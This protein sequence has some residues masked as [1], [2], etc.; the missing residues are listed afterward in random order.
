MRVLLI[1][2]NTTLSPYPV[3]P[4]GMSMVAAA[5]KE[6]G[7]EVKLYDCLHSEEGEDGCRRVIQDFKPGVIGVSIRNVD[8]VNAVDEEKYISAIGKIVSQIKHSTSVPVVLGGSGFSVMPEAVMRHVP[9]DYGIVGEGEQLMCNLVDK[10]EMGTPPRER[11]LVAN[12]EM[13]GREIPSSFYDPDLTKRYLKSGRMVAVQTKRGCD[14]RCVY[15][16]YP[17]IEGRRIRSRD[18][19]QVVD[20]LEA[21]IADHS[22]KYIFFVDSVFNDRQGEYRNVVERMY[23][24]KVHVKWTAFFTPATELDEEIL[25]KMKATGL[26]AVE[27]GADASSD[28]TLKAMAK[29]FSWGVVERFNQLMISHSIHTAHYFMFGGPGETPETVKQG[30]RNI[31]SLPSTANFMFMGIRILPGTVLYKRALAE[32][33]LSAD[34]DMVEPVYYFSPEIDPD[35]LADTLKKGFADQPNCVFPPNELDKDLQGLHQY[36]LQ[37]MGYHY[38]AKQWKPENLT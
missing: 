12:L 14:R 30:I 31:R 8:N 7:H 38:L 9:A 5:L 23:Q 36:G 3:Y 1:S 35:W 25:W 6:C 29:G 2:S 17:V 34:H 21:L 33:I 26:D 13:T 28:I 10:L 11:L 32:G 18:P 4:L 19:D 24:R 37:G 22:V 20:D 16:S 27:I 15:C